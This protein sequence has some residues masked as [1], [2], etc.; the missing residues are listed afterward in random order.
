MH[1]VISQFFGFWRLFG[2]F[3][4]LWAPVGLFF[5]FW[6]AWVGY[7][8]GHFLSQIKT[9]LLEVTVPRD[10]A[11]SPKA[12]ESIFAGIHGTTKNPDLVE[13]FWKGFILPWFSFEIVGDAAGVHFYVWT[14]DTFRRMIESQIYAQYPS[15]EIREVEDYTKELPA[16]VPN[17]DWTLWGTEMIL[18]KHDAFPIRTYDDFTL[19][20]I[21]AKEEDRKIDPLSSLVEFMGSLQPG[22]RCWVQFLARPTGDWWKKEGE[23][24][25]AK[26]IGREPKS[27]PNFLQRVFD[28]VIS[29]FGF[30]LP[31]PAVTIPEKKD[32]FSLFKLTP[33]QQDVVKA[34]EK[35]MSKIGFEVGFRWMYLARKDAFN[36]VGISA[37]F[38][39]FK[40]FA[41]QS[42]NGFKPHMKTI[43][44]SGYWQYTPLKDRIE[45]RRRSRLYRAYRLRS[46]FAPP[47]NTVRP[48]VLSSSELA[49]VY[50]FPGTVV[51]APTMSR[52]DAKKG[53]APPNLPF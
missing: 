20:D 42:L 3:W 39:I 44:K 18:T 5:I 7:V 50:H 9:I 30:F 33:G 1:D 35:N 22:E 40:Q 15:S 31:S 53:A 11:K 16:D 36:P 13:R 41:S 32:D 4:Y 2:A 52:L 38:G 10:V 12:M 45:N 21:S 26:I 6:E 43:V 23:L 47:F 24:E 51:A 29:F 27:K 37:M 17:K 19:E 14:H 8:R 25:I 34:V 49:T 48:F 46:F 28:L